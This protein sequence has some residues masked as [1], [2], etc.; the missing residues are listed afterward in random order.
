[1][2][3]YDKK[4]T[5]ISLAERADGKVNSTLMA[6]PAAPAGSIRTGRAVF[7]CSPSRIF[8]LI[9]RYSGGRDATYNTGGSNVKNFY[10]GVRA[11]GRSVPGSII[12][13]LTFSVIF[14][15]LMCISANSFVYLPFTPVPITMQVFTVLLS[16]IMLGGYWSAV[17]QA[18]Y[19][20]LGIMGMPV[21]A[22]FKSGIAAISGPTGGYIAGFIAAAFVTGYIFNKSISA[23]TGFTGI[24]KPAVIMFVACLS[25][26]TV[27]YSAG[28][29][30]L[31]GYLYLIGQGPV[32]FISLSA[33]AFKI[34]VA[35]FIIPDMFK[36]AII[37][38]LYMFKGNNEKD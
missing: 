25:G 8:P 37:L 35:P 21:F 27:I 10:E 24:K 5:M 20:I 3:S 12:T 23:R 6:E 38:N 28:F 34:G 26:L 1:L 19:L 7:P 18:Q 13:K 22:G 15:F 29:I 4:N 14:A 33:D 31:A 9:A 16:G 32:S 30:H 36:I 17:S 11:N 2:G